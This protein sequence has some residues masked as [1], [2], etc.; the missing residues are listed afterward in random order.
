VIADAVGRLGLA[1][2]KT[3]I[4]MPS[5]TVVRV[6]QPRQPESYGIPSEL[7]PQPSPEFEV[8]SLKLQTDGHGPTAPLRAE[9][10][11][12]VLA[13]AMPP[14]V[15][16]Q[17]AWNLFSWHQ[18]V[19]LPK[20]FVNVNSVTSNITIVAK[21]PDGLLP[22]SP[23]EANRWSRD[24]MYAMLK[25]LLIDRYQV[26]FHFEQRMV[27]SIV[28]TATGKHGLTPADPSGR[29]GCR[30]VGQEQGGAVLIVKISCRN[31]TMA[32]FVE[33]LPSFDPD[34]TFP[35]QDETG[36]KGAW[37]FTFSY[38]TL[39]R[40]LLPGTRSG[41]PTGGDGSDA[42][43]DPTGSMSLLEALPKQLGLRATT[44]K[45]PG[46]VLVVDSMLN[47]PVEN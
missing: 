9:A 8:A 27:D 24:V 18:I 34:I 23:A 17:Q 38:D 37:D 12:R 26:R 11:G 36:L 4:L 5:V 15:L 14:A 2:E 10:G 47:K 7:P 19:G 29:T 13:H 3:E 16:F 46:R 6:T 32:Q 20:S 28:L 30:Q 44:Q 40:R 22:D 39:A 45:R 41:E 1:I 43:S 21:A 35:A 25:S 42:A 33:Q 31:M